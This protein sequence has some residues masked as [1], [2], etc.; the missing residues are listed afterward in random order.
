VARGEVGEIRRNIFS[1]RS[2]FPHEVS[3]SASALP[4]AG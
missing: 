1:L 3:S 2:L 4:T